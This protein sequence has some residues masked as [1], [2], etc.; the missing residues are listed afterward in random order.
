MQ[1]DYITIEREEYDKLKEQDNFLNALYST[2]IIY[3]L[4]FQVA[5]NRHLSA[6]QQETLC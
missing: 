4:E 3:T 2:D 1:D 5:L 6:K